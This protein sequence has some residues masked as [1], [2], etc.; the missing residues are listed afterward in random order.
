MVP[1]AVLALLYVM[2]MLLRTRW[3]ANEDLKMSNKLFLLPHPTSHRQLRTPR[4]LFHCLVLRPPILLQLT[5]PLS[6]SGWMQR[7][8]AMVRR[9]H[10][11]LQQSWSVMQP[12][13]TPSPPQPRV[14]PWP[15][16]LAPEVHHPPRHH[17]SLSPT[18]CLHLV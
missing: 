16:Q 2:I 12:P 18:N 1:L 15:L 10:S 13:S 11:A 8:P 3:V 6:C 7:R 9:V 4:R 17:L 5:L 14:Q